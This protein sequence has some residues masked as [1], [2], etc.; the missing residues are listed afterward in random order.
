MGEHS[1]APAKAPAFEDPGTY[2]GTRAID[3][4]DQA[5]STYLDLPASEQ[6]QKL[7][8]EH[9]NDQHDP[10]WA[11]IRE[12][13]TKRF[14]QIPEQKAAQAFYDQSQQVIHGAMVRKIQDRI[15]QKGGTSWT[16]VAQIPGMGGALSQLQTH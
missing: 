10:T 6:R 1:G 5:A 8:I 14:P 12:D 3:A 13:F 2:L 16:G 4:G 15:E 7:P 11:G 9:F